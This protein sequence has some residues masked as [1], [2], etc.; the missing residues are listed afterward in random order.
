MIEIGWLYGKVNSPYTTGEIVYVVVVIAVTVSV[1]AV[2]IK[3]FG[4]LKGN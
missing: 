2:G 1:G 3:S 4:N